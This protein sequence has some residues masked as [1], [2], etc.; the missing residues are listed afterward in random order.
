MS[1]FA[2]ANENERALKQHVDISAAHCLSRQPNAQEKGCP[3]V[4]ITNQAV[5]MPPQV[6]DG[7]EPAF[8]N[9]VYRFCSTEKAHT[10][11]CWRSNGNDRDAVEI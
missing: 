1:S 8:F 4:S 7:D 3:N 5:D 6:H 9:A 10:S 11:H 2:T